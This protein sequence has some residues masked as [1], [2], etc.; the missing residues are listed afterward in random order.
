[1]IR[2]LYAVTRYVHCLINYLVVYVPFQSPTVSKGQKDEAL[3]MP[4]WQMLNFLPRFFHK[5]G[6]CAM[7]VRTEKPDGSSNNM[8]VPLW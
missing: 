1:M 7:S 6:K 5:E 8:K 2:N 4:Y 3:T